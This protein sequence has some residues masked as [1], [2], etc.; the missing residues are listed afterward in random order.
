M[1]IEVLRPWLLII[2]PVLFLFF[3][4]TI[5]LLKIKQNRTLLKSLVFHGITGCLLVLALS[6]IRVRWTSKTIT[7][8]YVVDLSDSTHFYQ[9][10]MQ[11][12][13]KDSILQMPSDQYAGIVTF[14]SEVKLEQ[15]VSEKKIFHKFETVPLGTGT[16]ME[17]AVSVAL[18]LLKEDTAKR[19]VLL[20]DGLE[21]SGSLE[22]M[23]S[24]V[25]SNRVDFKVVRVEKND[26]SEAYVNNLEIPPK[27]NIG[28]Q[29]SVKI[30]IVSNRNMGAVLYLYSGQTLKAQQNVELHSG[31]N[32]FV[33]KDIQEEGGLKTYRVV[34]D[35]DED[36][37]SVNNEYSAFTNVQ[38]P[39]LILLVEGQA[40]ASDEFVKLLDAVN[41]NYRLVTPEGTP[42]TMNQMLEYKSII[43]VDVY[44]GDLKAG[45][46]GAV[47]SYVKDYGGGMIAI[48]GENSFALGNYK[49]TPLET[50]L[51]VYMDLQGEKE[52][53]PLS[54]LLVIDKSGSMSD[55][56]GYVTNLD[57]A[58]EAAVKALENLR[59]IDRIGILSFD[60]SYTWTN[61]LILAKDKAEITKNIMGIP[62][63]GGTSIYPALK[64]AVDELK[65]DDGKLKHI[66]LLTDG[67]DGYQQYNDVIKELND[68]G[69]TLSTVSVGS[70]AD[71]AL[72]KDL[73]EKGAGRYFHTDINT[74][75]P[76]IFAQEV[77]LSVKSYLVNQE[78]TP[79]IAGNHEILEPI[80]EEG[81]PLM[82]GYI[83]STKKEFAQSLLISD[84]KEPILTVWQY[85]LGRTAAFN[86]DVENKWTG[87]YAGWAPYSLLWKN[88]IDYT[89]TDENSPGK[90]VRVE[91]KGSSAE[92]I[93][94]TDNSD[95]N[96]SVMA[97]Y[98]YEDGS[99]DEITLI[100]KAPGIYS[101]EFQTNQVGVYSINVRQEEDGEVTGSQNTAYVMQYS[102]EYRFA[103]DTPVLDNFVNVVKGM[104]ITL[105]EEVFAGKIDTVKSRLPLTMLWLVLAL[106]FFMADV[107]QRRFQ[108]KLGLKEKAE[109]KLNSFQEINQRKR[110]EKNRREE[111]GK[112]KVSVLKKSI[113]KPGEISHNKKNPLAHSKENGR[114]AFSKGSNI[115]NTNTKKESGSIL[116]TKELLSRKKER[117]DR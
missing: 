113:A 111:E 100:P 60:D 13:I 93:Y 90:S 71:V 94:Q 44:G 16:N 92:I 77:F 72:L 3:I 42:E 62:L 88:I 115:D 66:I 18:A 9:D 57:L 39:P 99:S 54:F 40:G 48:G 78:F 73:A 116:N 15:F 84:D 11:T 97:V 21:N 74:N 70:G 2:I 61:K 7:T 67:Q 83:A 64:A 24:S 91:D 56:N 58:K 65:A 108:L 26:Q 6:G 34:M 51:P 19:I 49:N 79:F 53:P 69:I 81:L 30:D 117:D 20:T 36:T 45:F 43:L 87:N 12:F 17:E 8:I 102:K 107:I 5:R 114:N 59:E 96:T 4:G 35:A 85:G 76:R 46:M 105:P 33:F 89:V 106:V 98:T 28:D 1:K 75:I 109:R 80:L 82:Y 103:E 104:F 63:G 29:F 47:E 10:N 41:V 38:A 110:E 32:Q 31:S 14:G 112:L 101:G 55:G 27:I 95:G 22:N 23:A 25:L 37:E 52:I 68:N 86:S 50:V